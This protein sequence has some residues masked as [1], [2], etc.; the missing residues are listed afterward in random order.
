[1]VIS[2]MSSLIIKIKNLFPYLIMIAIYFLFINLEAQNNYNKKFQGTKSKNEKKTNEV[3]PDS[4]IRISIPVI[5]Y[6]N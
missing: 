6:N 2:Q 3:T 5:P 1:M 4:N